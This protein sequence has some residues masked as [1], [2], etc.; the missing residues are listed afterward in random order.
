MLRK[1]LNI[2]YIVFFTQI[3]Y[4]NESRILR[5]SNNDGLSNSS[6]TTIF[7]DSNGLIWVGTWDGLNVYNGAEFENYR[8]NRQDSSSITNPV[9]RQIFEENKN[10]LWITTDYGDLT[11][12]QKNS[13]LIIWDIKI[14][15]HLENTLFSQ[16]AIQKD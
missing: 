16:L 14:K 1:I 4:A 9:I 2:A 7:Q 10:I 15:R 12:P 11:S 6:I 13:N 3:L 8:S 5:L